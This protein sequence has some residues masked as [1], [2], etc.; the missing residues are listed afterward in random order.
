MQD[1]NHDR[2]KMSVL[3]NRQAQLHQHQAVELAV[4]P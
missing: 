3:V 2:L 4:I 1:N